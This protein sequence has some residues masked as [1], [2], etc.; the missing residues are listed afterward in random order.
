MTEE[1]VAQWC[2]TNIK[3]EIHHGLLGHS[4]KLFPSLSAGGLK[5]DDRQTTNE[6]TDEPTNEP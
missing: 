2:R 1:V 5:G 6:P 4:E 3:V